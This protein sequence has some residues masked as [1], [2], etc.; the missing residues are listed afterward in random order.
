MTRDLS[1]ESLLTIEPRLKLLLEEVKDLKYVRNKRAHFCAN[2]YWLY[3]PRGLGYSQ[4][5]QKW[6]GHDPKALK[7]ASEKIYFNLPDCKKCFC[8]TVN[9]IPKSKRL[10]QIH[11][12]FKELK[13][14]ATWSKDHPDDFDALHKEAE[15]IIEKLESLGVERTF[16][17]SILVF[18]PEITPEMALQFE[19]QEG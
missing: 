6:L 17:Q 4:L 2:S 5:L 15:P 9:L 8:S 7:V 19:D 13:K 3:H 12:L 14:A 11:Q 1:W 18:G 16:S 10:I